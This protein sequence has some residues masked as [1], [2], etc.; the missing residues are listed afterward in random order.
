MEIIKMLKHLITIS[1]IILSALPCLFAQN[2]I[3]PEKLKAQNIRTAT[4]V[5]TDLKMSNNFSSK[6]AN[7]IL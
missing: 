7:T 2:M 5:T 4:K 1:F 3:E 6:T